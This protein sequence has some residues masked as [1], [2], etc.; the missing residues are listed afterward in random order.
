LRDVECRLVSKIE[1]VSSQ[2]LSSLSIKRVGIQFESLS[3]PQ[4]VKI[5]RL[6][7]MQHSKEF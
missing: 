4:Q 7:R 3:V 5:N 6:V 1:K 2:S